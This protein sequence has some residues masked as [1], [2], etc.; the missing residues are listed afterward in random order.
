MASLEDLLKFTKVVESSVCIEESGEILR[1]YY[2]FR[3]SKNYGGS[4]VG[5]VLGCNL[6]CV[7]CWC[8]SINSKLKLGDYR[9]PKDVVEILLSIARRDGFR[10]VRLSGG[11]PTLCF[12]HLV[13][14]LKIFASVRRSEV[15][16]VETNGIVLG[17]NDDY[18]RRLKP[19]RSA[20]V[21]RLSIKGCSEEEFEKITGFNRSV[22]YLQIK[23]LENLDAEG[24]PYTVA[25]PIS[26]CSKNSFSKL[27]EI[28]TQRIGDHVFNY[29]EPEVFILY[30]STVRRLCKKGLK[31]WILYEPITRR[32]IGRGEVDEFFRELCR[33][34]GGRGSEGS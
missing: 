5:D 23:A 19:Y 20:I 8:W 26:F 14:V 12:D 25:I 28:L 1:R 4:A 13:N 10:I 30:P 34:Q 15:F 11:E 6:G 27:V 31:P 29:L 33:E 32:K 22:F 7:Y 16:V 9:K 24:I 3:V 21:V 18:V 2:R 17:V